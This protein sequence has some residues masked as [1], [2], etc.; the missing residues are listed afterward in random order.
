MAHVVT[1]APAKFQLLFGE[2]VLLPL[3]LHLTE[4][5]FAL[6]AQLHVLVAGHD[7]CRRDAEHAQVGGEQEKDGG[8]IAHA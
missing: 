3:D 6:D 2:L 5:L 4:R 1:V 8:E 7:I